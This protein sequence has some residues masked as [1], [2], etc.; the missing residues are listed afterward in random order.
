MIPAP[1]EILEAFPQV[2]QHL[3]KEVGYLVFV[4]GEHIAHG[5]NGALVFS[6]ELPSSPTN[7]FIIQF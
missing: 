3:L 7:V 4:L 5:V 6:D 2:D 1:L